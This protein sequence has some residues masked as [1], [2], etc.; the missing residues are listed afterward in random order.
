MDDFWPTLARSALTAAAE[1]G[2]DRLSLSPN[3]SICFDEGR[4]GSEMVKRLI[5]REALISFLW[6]VRRTT[7]K[8]LEDLGDDLDDEE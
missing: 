4:F 7:G 2:S 1:S 8:L 5:E 6:R 3:G